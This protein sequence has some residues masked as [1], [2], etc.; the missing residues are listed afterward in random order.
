MCIRDRIY[1]FYALIFTT[2][3]LLVEGTFFFI[4]N[5]LP[6]NRSA[7]YRM[8]MI[9]K[10]G[11]DSIGLTLLKE[12]ARKRSNIH[13]LEKVDNVLL[14]ANLRISAIG[15][16]FICL[17]IT[18]TIFSL[19]TIM[20]LGSFRRILFSIIGGI[21]LPILIVS[22]KAQKRRD[23]FANQLVPAIDLSLIHI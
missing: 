21:I 1:I 10:T 7:N 14:A 2:V 23:L 3:I 22:R 18:I 15:F 11:D 8:K 12:Q 17:F 13:L 16:V 19:T 6:S 5:H 9:E 4:R 20:G